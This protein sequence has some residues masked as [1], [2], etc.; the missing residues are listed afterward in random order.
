MGFIWQHPGSPFYACEDGEASWHNP[1]GRLSDSQE[2]AERVQGAECVATSIPF[3]VNS[4]PWHWEV[5]QLETHRQC[6]VR[7][8]NTVPTVRGTVA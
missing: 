8:P 1:V 2:A 5:C 7:G 3:D 4:L 6:P